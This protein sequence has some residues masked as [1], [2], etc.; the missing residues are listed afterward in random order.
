MAFNNDLDDLIN[1]LYRPSIFYVPK[2]VMKDAS[3][4][5]K[6]ELID[7]GFFDTSCIL[8]ADGSLESIKNGFI[9]IQMIGKTNKLDNNVFQ[10]LKFRDQLATDSFLF[11]KREYMR[12]VSAIEVVYTWLLDNIGVETDCVTEQQRTWFEYQK[13][14]VAQHDEK[15]RTKF[16]LAE[17]VKRMDFSKMNIR[18]PNLFKNK[19]YGELFTES[20]E[21]HKRIKKQTKG[22]RY[23]LTDSEAD[24]YLLKTVFNVDFSKIVD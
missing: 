18:V 10:L 19:R 13:N 12:H 24:K 11:I 16:S 6:Q 9:E 21:D 15:L 8:K 5:S 4:K 23:K 3:E 17:R 2:I 7:I 1:G 14:A 22:K 20:L